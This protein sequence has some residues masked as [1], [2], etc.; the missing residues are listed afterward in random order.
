MTST[1][2]KQEERR[3]QNYHAPTGCLGKSHDILGRGCVRLLCHVP[4]D[5]VS[6]SRGRDALTLRGGDPL[7]S[8]RRP[9]RTRE[10][11][12]QDAKLRGLRR[13]V[14]DGDVST[15]RI[16]VPG[17]ESASRIAIRSGR[18]RASEPLL[19]GA[20]CSDRR[21]FQGRKLSRPRDEVSRDTLSP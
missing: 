15:M 9:Y 5:L 17:G 3:T 16:R 4:R 2:R 19:T 1:I 10:R 6:R 21:R 7:Q 18:P 11:C 12:S 8:L 13:L 20:T 14:G